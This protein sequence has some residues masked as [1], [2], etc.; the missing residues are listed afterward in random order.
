[1]ALKYRMD[2]IGDL[3]RCKISLNCQNVDVLAY[4]KYRDVAV[5][6]CILPSSRFF[7]SNPLPDCKRSTEH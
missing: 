5:P 4:L 2:V 1:M 6:V 7:S 3:A